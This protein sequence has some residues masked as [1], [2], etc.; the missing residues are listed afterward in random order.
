MLLEP[1]RMLSHYRLVEK[2]GEGGMG[3]VWKA[4]DTTLRRDVALKILPDVFAHDADRR[5]R[6]SREARL[7]A[8]LNHPNIAAIHGFEEEDGVSF[9]VLEM[10]PGEDLAERIAAGPVEVSEALAIA[11]QIAEGVEAAHAK[12]VI[13]RDLKP[14]NVKVTEEGGVKVLDFGLA[15]AFSEGSPAD[16]LSQ[17]PTITEMATRDGIIMGTAGYMS[18]EQAKGRAVDRRTDIWA[19]GCVLYEM[20]TGR[21]AFASDSVAASLANILDR[22]PDWDALPAR[23]PPRIQQLLQRCLRKDPSRRLRDIGDLWIEVDE[24]ISGREWIASGSLSSPGVLGEG[25]SRWRLPALLA[26]VA[27]AGAA[28]AIGLWTWLVPDAAA[29]A[30]RMTHLSLT[31]PPGQ[32]PGFP[33]VSPDGSTVAYISAPAAGQEGRPMLHTR[34]IDRPEAA[35]VPGSVGVRDLDFSPDGRWIAFVAPPQ[36]APLS[37]RKILFKIPVDGS[38]PPV[39]I[40][41]WPEGVYPILTWPAGGH[42]LALGEDEIHRFPV[43]GGQQDTI[44]FPGGITL[45]SSALPGGQLLGFDDLRR[46]ILYDIDSGEVQGLS[47]DAAWPLWSPTGH[48]LFTRGETL[49]ALPFDPERLV[50]TGGPIAIAT[51]IEP[52]NGIYPGRFDISTEGTLVYLP[53]GTASREVEIVLVDPDGRVEPWSG[54]YRIWH[55]MAVS[56]DGKR[57]AVDLVN[58]A[59]GH[60]E[61]WVS[62]VQR[63]RLRRV[64]ADPDLGCTYPV[65]SPDGERIAF[66]CFG[67]PE[68]RGIFIQRADGTGVPER[69][70]E[71]IVTVWSFTSDGSAVLI[72]RDESVMQILP[73]E[74]DADGVR[75][76]RTLVEGSGIRRAALSPDG[77]WIAYHGEDHTGDYGL[78]LREYRADGTV[79]P[80]IPVSRPGEGPRARDVQPPFWSKGKHQDR[81]ELF[82][83]THKG[84]MGASITAAPSLEVSDPYV[85]LD[86]K[87]LAALGGRFR[88]DVLPDGRFVAFRFPPTAQPRIEVVLNWFEALGRGVEPGG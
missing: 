62:E 27:I 69:L 18:P 16:V 59:T 46:L 34:R 49:H 19:F 24:A 75:S 79:G 55:Y 48:I 50:A 40:V 68:K 26:V 31:L 6:F 30:P 7:L 54:P 47:D 12:G 43:D 60:M 22:E 73:V 5:T 57:L 29:P 66:M 41:D 63:P 8:S 35:V 83:L 37:A 70:L 17:S 42:I 32:K 71:E 64:V 15:K 9:L 33:H 72:L 14:A 51:G 77:R 61:I 74:P 2:I 13:H 4:E 36:D 11:R 28:T 78:L 38:A 58:A 86:E 25:G 56:P 88:G 45:L 10:V 52:Y 21:A 44:P 80:P 3:V 81:M 20:L 53:G 1:G 84:L 65:W 82:Y 67:S 85:V 76:A 39:R 87:E 23:T